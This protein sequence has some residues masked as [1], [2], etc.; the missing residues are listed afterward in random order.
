VCPAD[1]LPQFLE[2]VAAERAVEPAV[3]VMPAVPVV[4][5][6]MFAAALMT[7]VLALG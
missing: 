3:V 7:V 5:A 2:A 1:R 6:V 4:L